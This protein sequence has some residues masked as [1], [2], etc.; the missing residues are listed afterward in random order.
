MNYWDFETNLQEWIRF[1]GTGLLSKFLLA[2]K[3]FPYNKI[4][5]D[6]E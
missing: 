5:D 1:E 2:I 4:D 3:G 6:G